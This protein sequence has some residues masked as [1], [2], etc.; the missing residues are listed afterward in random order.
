[1]KGFLIYFANDRQWA[2]RDIEAASAAEALQ[3]ARLIATNHPRTLDYNAYE[4]LRP[5]NQ[6]EVLDEYGEELAVWHDGDLRLRLAAS[7]LLAAAEKVVT[8]WER[9]DLAGAVRELDVA[10][11]KAKAGAG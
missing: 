3:R 8:R 11:A 2:E 5:I 6:I 10:I 4:G 9:G 1:M 7:D